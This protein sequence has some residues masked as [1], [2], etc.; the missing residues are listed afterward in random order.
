[1]RYSIPGVPGLYYDTDAESTALSFA[2]TAAG[3]R[4]PTPKGYALQV[5]PFLWSFDV[6]LREV[7]L[8]HPMQFLHPEGARELGELTER[9]GSRA[10]GRELEAVLRFVWEIDRSVETSLRHLASG[11][12]GALSAD[13]GQTETSGTVID[14]EDGSITVDG[15]ELPTDEFDPGEVH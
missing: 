13:P 9:G 10:I 1:M 11:N 2:L 4:A 14:I 15:E 3:R 5:L 7:P 8:D 6:D 12:Y